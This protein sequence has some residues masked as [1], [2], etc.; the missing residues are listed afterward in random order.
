[1]IERYANVPLARVLKRGRQ[2]A[3]IEQEEAADRADMSREHLQEIESGV[4][5]PEQHEV[6]R[7]ATNYGLDIRRVGYGVNVLTSVPE[8]D[9]AARTLWI[10]WLPIHLGEMPS[11]E[12][13]M[14]RVAV[15]LRF[16]RDLPR[17]DPIRMRSDEFDM[18]ISALDVD[19][20]ELMVQGARAFRLPWE[21]ARVLFRPARVRRKE[22][23]VTSRVRGLMQA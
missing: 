19:D 7:L 16:L 3:N 20:P 10:E 18:L 14:H 23:D 17:L 4:L 13:V 5:H 8:L 21:E 15:G 2:W 11:N 9:R 22:L 6:D 12:E 1:M